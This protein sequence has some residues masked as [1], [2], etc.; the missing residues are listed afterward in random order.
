MNPT[1]KFDVRPTDKAWE[2]YAVLQLTLTLIAVMVFLLGGSDWLAAQLAQCLLPMVTS[3]SMNAM[4]GMIFFLLIF[5]SCRNIGQVMEAQR[6]E[7]VKS[8][9]WQELFRHIIFG[10]VLVPLAVSLNIFPES[11]GKYGTDSRS[12][13][14]L[15]LGI[16]L[17]EFLNIGMLA[18][19]YTRISRY[20]VGDSETQRAHTSYIDWY[21]SR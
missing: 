7:K 11:S 6:P 16:G 8:I 20:H 1:E 18:R 17:Y 9:W 3:A 2:V 10:A 5:W 13:T 14:L 21:K 15:S 19:L 12:G 4:L